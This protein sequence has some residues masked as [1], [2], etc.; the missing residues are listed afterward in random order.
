MAGC[1]KRQC[2]STLA[3]VEITDNNILLRNNNRLDR[4]KRNCRNAEQCAG[5]CAKKNDFK[6]LW[7]AELT[8]VHFS[9]FKIVFWIS[10]I[11]ISDIQISRK[12]VL[13]VRKNK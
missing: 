2:P 9:D 6:V 4:Q 12:N 3:A 13:N 8:L 5:T 11:V 1:Q 7:Q 10:K